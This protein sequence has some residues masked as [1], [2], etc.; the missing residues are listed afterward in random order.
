MY[1]PIDL[2]FSNTSTD[3]FHLGAVN[4]IS[5]IKFRDKDSITYHTPVVSFS[6]PGCT[7]YNMNF[8]FKEKSMK[9]DK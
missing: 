4:I 1:N 2:K 3:G 8:F 6:L 7:K 9:V 5:V